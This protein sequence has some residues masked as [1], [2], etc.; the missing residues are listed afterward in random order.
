MYTCCII[1]HAC[2]SPVSLGGSVA[3]VGRV[4]GGEGGGGGGGGISTVG[5]VPLVT[6]R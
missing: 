5:I 2:H 3:M 4:E 6:G 1:V